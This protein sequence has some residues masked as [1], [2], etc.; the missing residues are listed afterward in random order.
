M[1]ESTSEAPTP[2]QVNKIQDLFENMANL[3]GALAQNAS[4]GIAPQ[5]TGFQLDLRSITVAL[6]ACALLGAQ[7]DKVIPAGTVDTIDEEAIEAIAV[8]AKKI[9]VALFGPMPIK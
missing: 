9:G 7:H 2:E 6:A 8:A 5:A 3:K 1:P 4:S